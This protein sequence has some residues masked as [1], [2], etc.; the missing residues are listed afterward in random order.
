MLLCT[1]GSDNKYLV[2]F[3]VKTYFK[4]VLLYEKHANIKLNQNF[5]Q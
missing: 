4:E 2:H 3:C 5:L 1:L